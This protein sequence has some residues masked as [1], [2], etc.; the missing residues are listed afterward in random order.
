MSL[1]RKLVR[2][3]SSTSASGTHGVGR[4]AN[5]SYR[6]ARRRRALSL[7]ALEDR[8]LLSLT[9]PM[10]ISPSGTITTNLPTFAWTS[11][12]GAD[13]YYLY[14]SD[15]TTGQTVVNNSN[16]PGTSFAP[17]QALTLG[18][19]YL[20]WVAAVN[21]QGSSWDSAVSFRIAPTAS[22]PAGTINTNVPTFTWSSVTGA[23]HYYLYVSDQTTGKPTVNNSNVSGTSFTPAQAL[24]LGDTYMW[25]VAAVNA[26]GT[27][28]DSAVSFRIAP[29][30]SGP[31]GAIGTTLPTFTWSSVAGADHYYLYVSDQTTGGT[32]VNDNNVSGTSFTPAQ[33]LTLGDTYVWWVAAVNSQGSG[34]DSALT[35][36][37]APTAS[38]PSGAIGT[39][40]PTFAWT[41]VTG[42]DHYY[43]YVSDQTTGKPLVNNS[44]VSGTSF[45]LTQ[46]LTLG[47]NYEWW[48]AAVSGNTTAWTSGLPFSVAPTLIGPGGLIT[49]DQ[50]T[51]TWTAVTGAASYELYVSD[52]QTGPVLDLKNL[53][54]TSLTLSAA[55]ALTPGHQFTWYVAAVSGQSTGWSSPLVFS[56]AP[57]A[58]PTPIL[59]P[60]KSSINTDQPTFTWS[61][62]AGAA[63]Y[64]LY[65]SDS[66]TGPVVDKNVNGTSYT[67]TAAQ[68]LTPGHSF[69]WYVAAVSTNGHAKV[70]GGP[71][72][73]SIDVLAAP[74]PN[75][76]SNTIATSQPTFTWSA[77]TDAGSY[78]LALLDQ[79]TGPVPGINGITGT[80]LTLSAAQAL[81]PNHSYQWYVAAV[82]T[83]GKVTV[84]SGAKSFTVTPGPVSLS[85]SVI[86]V[87]A[88]GIQAGTYGTLTLT[89]RDANG[90]L[91]GSG[92][93]V[94]FSVAGG[95]PIHASY[96][97]HGT[98]TASFLGT[99]A[100]GNSVTATI[101]GQPV[102]SPAATLVVTPGPVSMSQ[103]TF[104]LSVQRILAGGTTAITLHAKDAYGNSVGGQNVVFGLGNSAVAGSF[105]A[106]EDIGGGTYLDTFTAAAATSTNLN[107]GQTTITAA[108][109]GKSLPT[110]APLTVGFMGSYEGTYFN[111]GGNFA[112]TIYSNGTIGVTPAQ[113]KEWGLYLSPG[114]NTID[115]AG[116]AFFTLTG[117]YG[118]W[119]AASWS[120]GDPNTGPAF[121]LS[122]GVITANGN[123]EIVG[124]GAGG[125]PQTGTWSYTP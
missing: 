61:A 74:T 60:D 33:P 14:G 50:P 55:Q 22:G 91:V 40:L 19:N 92:L 12:A 52:Q 114:S 83:N 36:R 43:L 119:Q 3:L 54:G 99:I 108:I 107:W 45:T 59:P 1:W 39:I 51:F 86:S 37:I 89:A 29:T 56:V 100:G 122:N 115:N 25:W 120:F 62:V 15:Q 66:L 67:L 104:S 112:I 87:P 68:A 41:S 121:S 47:H 94:A 81:E 16:V 125:G 30:A 58:A 8:C 109:N 82:S 85:Q 97:G 2:L 44:N 102:T 24:T 93:S 76:P 117:P 23:D 4:I 73:F 34:W 123:L 116:N 88:G 5:P 28:W 35:F 6:A 69:T 26:Q 78:D 124:T 106:T 11:V 64:E 32:V 9:A 72:T 105:F 49:T 103:S 98:Y 10:P 95:T 65:I 21:A 71:Q 38:G 46:A 110:S 80:S 18:D 111:G 84:W 53:T 96:A 31:S 7:E 27:G 20:W 77:V 42:A 101:G 90:N 48:V 113:Y 17:A 79:Q 75:L 57:L 118:F 63:S 13:H 70:W